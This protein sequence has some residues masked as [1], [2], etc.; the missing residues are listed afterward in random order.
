M[1]F[2][3]SALFILLVAVVAVSASHASVPPVIA[4]QGR[5]M[6]SSGAPVADGVY[7]MQFAIYDVG[8][9]GTPLWSETNPSVQAKGGL[10][11]VLLGSVNGLSA[12][13]FDGDRW[14]AVKM[15]SDPEMTPRQ[16][17][18]SSPFAFRAAVAGTVDDG[19]VTTSK[20]ADNAVTDAKVSSVSGSKVTG[21]V[22]HAALAD[23]A[24]AL[25]GVPASAFV[26]V[27]GTQPKIDRGRSVVYGSYVWV[28]FNVTFSSP[29]R[30]VCQAAPAGGS[31]T[32]NVSLSETGVAATGFYAYGNGNFWFDWIAVGE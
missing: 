15:G 12:N 13:I 14:L 21:A 4:Y 9:G 17:V 31:T 6:Q 22:P 1:T 8:M 11:C 7:S 18:V 2:G 32:S 3:K 19:A 5:L 25:G 26:Q 16:Q 27:G 30:V 28:P 10:F 23:N 24:S 20:I 29:P